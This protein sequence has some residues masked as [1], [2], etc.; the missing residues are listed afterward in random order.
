MLFILNLITVSSLLYYTHYNVFSK[1]KENIK[2]YINHTIINFLMVLTTTSDSIRLLE[3]KEECHQIKPYGGIIYSWHG[4]DNIELIMLSNMLLLHGYHLLLFNNLRV[5]DYL[6]HI[7]MMVILTMAYMMNVGVY[8]SYFLFFICGLPGMIDY[9]MLSLQYNRRTEKRINSYL[10]NYIRAPG[11][12]F[13]L[14]MFWRDIKRIS[15]FYVSFSFVTLFW[16]AQYFNYE[17]I[18]SYYSL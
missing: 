3:C 7:L 6:H 15:L 9:S 4:Y 8:M 2:W 18:K 17:V 1:C 12:M 16:N 5:I 10:N 13:G 14:G 11:I